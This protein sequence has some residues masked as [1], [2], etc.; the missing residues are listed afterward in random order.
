MKRL[1][2]VIALLVPLITFSQAADFEK[3]DE[4]VNTL[5]SDKNISIPDLTRK[6]TDPFNDDL[7]KVRSVF[8]WLASN[9][10]YDSQGIGINP[11]SNAP[12]EKEIINETFRLRKGDCRGYSYLFR[13]MLGLSGIRSRIITGYTRVD[14]NSITPQKP[15]HVWN[16][17]RINGRWHLF[18]VTWAS[19]TT[20]K[21]NDFWFRTDPDIFILNHYPVYRS[22]AY[23][24]NR[25]SFDDFIRF[26]VYTN[27]F[28][29]FK[30]T[31]G[32][33]RIG[34]FNAVDDTVRIS[35]KPRFEVV[36][37]TELYDIQNNEWISLLP[38]SQV[39][40]DDHLKLFIPAKGNFVLKLGAMIKDKDTYSIY[41]EL[42]FYTISNK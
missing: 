39:R 13:H 8:S 9:I 17:A 1:L 21:V 28:H 14:F 3:V 18:D 22:Y 15:N 7:L 40:G 30:F 38:G 37:L 16:S 32:I 4:Y 41:D 11:G 35:M 42:V 23:T 2:L 29:K 25:Y 33:S 31:E 27:Q 5:D 10:S 19:D 6:L 20:R 36:L 34:H 26:P 24:K 12:S